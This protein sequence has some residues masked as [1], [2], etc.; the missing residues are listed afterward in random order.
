MGP[1]KAAAKGAP[2]LKVIRS[3]DTVHPR[4]V[5]LSDQ[6]PSREG[7]AAQ[8]RLRVKMRMK[9]KGQGKSKSIQ[10]GR[11]KSKPKGRGKTKSQDVM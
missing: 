1:V 5:S 8:K 7:S 9:G 2:N 10:K 4:R 11:S 3:S 6:N